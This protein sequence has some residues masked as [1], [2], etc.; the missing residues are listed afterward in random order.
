MP[1]G[2]VYRGGKRPVIDAVVAMQL[3]LAQECAP[4]LSIFLSQEVTPVAA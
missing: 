3:G 4:P 2:V 1:T